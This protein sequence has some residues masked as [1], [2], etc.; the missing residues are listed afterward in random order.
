[1]QWNKEGKAIKILRTRFGGALDTGKV[2]AAYGL[3][4]LQ[5]LGGLLTRPIFEAYKLVDRKAEAEIINKKYGI[6]KKIGA[7]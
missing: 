4:G 5:S 1:M 6:G 2:G 7:G 3:Y